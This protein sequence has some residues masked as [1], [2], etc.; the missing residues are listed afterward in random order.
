MELTRRKRIRFD[1]ELKAR[2]ALPVPPDADLFEKAMRGQTPCE[3][4]QPAYI[5]AGWTKFPVAR[6]VAQGLGVVVCGSCRTAIALG[7]LQPATTGGE[8]C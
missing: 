6:Y 1:H 3:V 5:R 2:T 8:S 4:C 7:W